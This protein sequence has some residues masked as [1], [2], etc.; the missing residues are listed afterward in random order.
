MKQQELSSASTEHRRVYH[1]T[2]RCQAASL[3]LTASRWRGLKRICPVESKK[4]AGSFA[5]HQSAQ[6]IL[7]W[8]RRS[9]GARR[10][11]PLSGLKDR[12]LITDLLDPDGVDVG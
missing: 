12:A 11:T 10:M 6:D 3:P 5:A 8:W 1:A 4:T 2:R 7:V 9:G